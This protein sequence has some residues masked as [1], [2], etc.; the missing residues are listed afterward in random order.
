VNENAAVKNENELTLNENG[1]TVNEN[2]VS[3]LVMSEN[4]KKIFL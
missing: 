4:D 1:L 2:Y 3:N